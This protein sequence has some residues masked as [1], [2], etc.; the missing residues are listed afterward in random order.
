MK[1][2]K[3]ILLTMILGFAW[4]TTANAQSGSGIDVIHVPT[5]IANDSVTGTVAN[6]LVYYYYGPLGTLG[7]PTAIIQPTT[8][9]GR[10]AGICINNCGTT[11]IAQ[12]QTDGNS[13]L[14]FDSAPTVNDYFTWSTTTAG[15]ATDMGISSIGN[16]APAAAIGYVEGCYGT[17]STSTA[18]IVKL[19]ANQHTNKA[20]CKLVGGGGSDVTISADGSYHI[21]GSCT[22]YG[23]QHDSGQSDTVVEF[24]Q[25]QVKLQL[26]AGQPAPTG[27][28]YTLAY[29]HSSCTGYSG[30]SNMDPHSIDV[31]A[32]PLLTDS[33]NIGYFTLVGVVESGN[34]DILPPGGTCLVSLEAQIFGTGAEITFKGDSGEVSGSG[35]H[36]GSDFLISAYPGSS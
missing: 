15:D 10:P 27:L 33:P 2:I 18:E 20:E 17:C 6:K 31:N 28:E 36:D 23:F 14:Y 13:N 19:G 35:S 24:T 16:P 30:G 1:L 34:S 8:A 22:L 12:I 21:I 25:G 11:G 26:V 29:S 4:H 5:F 32:I 3:S 7:P 9:V